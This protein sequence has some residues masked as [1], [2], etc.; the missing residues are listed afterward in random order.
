MDDTDLGAKMN[1]RADYDGLPPSH[2]LRVKAELFRVAALGY[3]GSPQ[4]CGA[5]QFLGAWARARKAWCNYTGEE[6]I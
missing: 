6:L 3:F 5:K 4:A 1:A 2:E